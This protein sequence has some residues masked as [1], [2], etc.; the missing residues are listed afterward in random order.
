MKLGLTLKNKVGGSPWTPDSIDNLIHWYKHDTGISTES[1]AA[2]SDGDTI[3]R[4]I[5]SKGTNHAVAEESN[6]VWSQSERAIKTNTNAGG[7]NI[8]T[9]NLTTFS[10]YCRIKFVDAIGTNDR[11]L[12]EAENSTTNFIRMNNATSIRCKIGGGNVTFTVPTLNTGQYY[13]IGIERH[14]VTGTL[15]TRC[16]I[17]GVESSSGAQNGTV[18]WVLDKLSMGKLDFF[19]TLIVSSR[20]L[21]SDERSELNT[22]LDNI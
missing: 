16:F 22:Y 4:W 19:K 20:H 15:T 17:D 2:P 9:L 10:V 6:S 18:T 5:D 12:L 13:N 11:W 7:L 14:A 3:A 8:S 21:S 1:G